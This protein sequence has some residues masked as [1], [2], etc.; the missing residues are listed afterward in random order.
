MKRYICLF[1]KYFQRI[2][3]F[4]GIIFKHTFSPKYNGIMLS[5]SA[6]NIM[7]GQATFLM[8]LSDSNRKPL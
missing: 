7:T 3:H 5:S 4:K 2:Y 6:C 8:C 1:F